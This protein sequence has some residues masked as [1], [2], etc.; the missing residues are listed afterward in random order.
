MSERAKRRQQAKLV[1]QRLLANP[2]GP[3]RAC[4]TT[5]GQPE[6]GKPPDVACNHLR[7]EGAS[8]GGCAMWQKRPQGCR[9]YFCAWRY[10]VVVE[11]QP[12]F[13]PDVLGV[14]FDIVEAAPPGILVLQARESQPGA[15]EA[16]HDDLLKIVETGA[17][18]YLVTGDLTDPLKLRARYLGW[19]HHVKRCVDHA[20]R[21]LPLVVPQD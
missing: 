20:R 8:G 9:D 19:E 1:E 4:C 21:H 18:L 6:L 15:F 7:P 5:K 3:C 14:V 12:A 16:R 17:V 10:G 13:R 2:C 11:G